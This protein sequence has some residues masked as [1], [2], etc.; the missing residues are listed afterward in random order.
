MCIM[1]DVDILAIIRRIDLNGNEEISV[2]DFAE[3]MKID[4]WSY[5]SKSAPLPY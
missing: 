4:S 1:E 3:F 2:L 5:L